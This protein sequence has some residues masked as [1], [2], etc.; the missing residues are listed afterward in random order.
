MLKLSEQELLMMKKKRS[1]LRNKKSIVHS[2]TKANN[3]KETIPV[4]AKKDKETQ[5]ETTSLPTSIEHVVESEEEPYDYSQDW[6]DYDWWG[7][8][9]VKKKRN[10]KDPSQKRAFDILGQF[11]GIES[12]ENEKRPLPES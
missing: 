7:Y 2:E 8:D 11:F 1:S 6:S 12:N 3:E 10:E 9:G 5:F 4:I